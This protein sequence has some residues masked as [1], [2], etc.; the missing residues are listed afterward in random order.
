[1]IQLPRF[2]QKLLVFAAFALFLPGLSAQD[3]YHNELK[4]QLF[5]AYALPAG[6]S[7]S[8]PD[9]ETAIFANAA[10]YGAAVTNF[11]PVGQPFLQARRFAVQQ[12]SNPWDAG[13]LYR[14]T[15]TIAAGDKCLLVIWLRG[16]TPD[17]RLTLLAENTT[18]YA[19]EAFAVLRLTQAWAQYLIPFTAAAAYAPNTLQIGVQMAWQ[20]Q[21]V[22]VGGAAVL[23]YHNLVN[24]DQLPVRLH[25][26]YYPGQEPNAPW[27][28][29]AAASIEQI[30]KANL[31]I[32]ALDA[33]GQPAPDAHIHV[34]MLQH[35][36]KFGTAV[37]SNRFGGGNAQNNTY[38]EKLLNLDGQGHGFNE[39]VFENDLKWPAWEQHWY[40]TWTEI[41]T[42]VQWLQARDISIRGHNLAWPGWSYSP[43]DL[44]PNQG[45]PNYLKTRIRNHLQ[46]ILTY[47]GVGSACADWDVLNEITQNNDYANALAGTPGYVTGREIY[48]E[49]FR[50]A[51]SLVPGSV[52]YLNDYVAIERGDNDDGAMAIWKTR[53]DELLAAGAPVEGIGFQGHFGAFPTGI[54][55]VN[56]IYDDFWNTY[57]LEAKVTEYDIDRLVPPATQADYMRDILTVTFAHPSQKGFLMWGFW[58]GAHWLSNAPIF[59]TDWSIK[60]SGTA[61]IDQV[62]NQWW[63]DETLFTGP[64]GTAT[65]RGFR[66]QYRVTVSC[67]D[68]GQEFFVTL[69]GDKT[70]TV[71]VDCSVGTQESDATPAFSVLPNLAR[72]QVRVH[73][74]G[75]QLQG[76]VTLHVT[77]AG[78]RLF[79]D[80]K[81]HASAG[82]CG[83][84][85]A[86]WPTGVYFL[87][88]ENEGKRRTERLTIAH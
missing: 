53:L 27:R 56:A 25:N 75:H 28:A 59:N 74:D 7:W 76:S 10:T 32:L 63:T 5:T 71:P 82:E 68:T 14:N 64:D 48:P 39:V 9:T 6:A 79:V 16:E 15:A 58:D 47:P 44:E 87:T 31:T 55:T 12:G 33:S 46:H 19:K 65:V 54:P 72:D 73:W 3:A 51:D 29:E 42:A 66:G 62:F 1:M 11:S 70:L 4:N 77:D 83:V 78:G 61:F 18:T 86:D 26:D 41:A 30:R 43:P 67:G 88:L 49:I 23:N 81:M 37:I 22:E 84:N 17:A 40:S 57:G 80:L 36:F 85:T 24:Y 35:A 20:T 52:L 69:D 45:N 21:T 38:A 34:E 13:H 8:L 50:Q 2:M 60:P